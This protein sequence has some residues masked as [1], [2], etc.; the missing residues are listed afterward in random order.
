MNKRFITLCL[1]TFGMLL[2]GCRITLYSG[3]PE[4]E[5]NQMLVLLMANHIDAGKETNKA[6]KLSLR[7]AKSQFIKSV[8]ILRQHGY[9]K[10]TYA[11][12][13]DVFPANQLV[14]SPEQ[15]RAKMEFLKEQQ[16]ESMLMRID[17]VVDARAAVGNATPENLGTNTTSPTV[18]VLIKYSPTVNLNTYL[19]QIRDLVRQSVAGVQDSNVSVVMLPAAYYMSPQ[20]TLPDTW[21]TR[22][23][24][25]PLLFGALTISL[26]VLIGVTI[27]FSVWQS[28]KTR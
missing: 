28:R 23:V 26:L 19:E 11:S 15:E 20:P 5:A 7:V 6:G 3:L 12:V 8:E 27:G 21:W 10:P 1:L 2:S 4:K 25:N 14:S 9:P 24:R 13:V 17:G 22:L 18:S 16:I